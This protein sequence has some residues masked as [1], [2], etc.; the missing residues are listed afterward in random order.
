MNK[1]I[2]AMMAVIVILLGIQAPSRAACPYSC[3][4][5]EV[6]AL[7]SEMW[8]LINNYRVNA[9]RSAL[10][11]NSYLSTAAAV[12]ANYMVSIQTATHTG[13]GGTNAAQRAVNAGYPV[14]RTIG[15]NVGWGY[16]TS[17]QRVAAWYNSSAH[18]AIML[19]STYRYGGVAIRYDSETGTPYYCLVV[20]S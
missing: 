20:G 1:I 5:A 11:R 7:Q 15:E 4:S 12:Q 3:T 17:A 9:G 18:R 6:S 16:S 10:W 14:G 13:L 2:V 8:T 19:S